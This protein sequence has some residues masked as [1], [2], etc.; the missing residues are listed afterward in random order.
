MEGQAGPATP[1]LPAWPSYDRCISL[2]GL[3]MTGAL[4]D[5]SVIA[6]GEPFYGRRLF[7]GRG[8]F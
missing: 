2:S 1:L 7:Y 8:P 5:V 6:N 3:S 4:P